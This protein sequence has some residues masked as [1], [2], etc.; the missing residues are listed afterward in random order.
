M[1]RI[2]Q[3]LFLLLFFALYKLTD[4]PFFFKIDPLVNFSVFLADKKIGLYLLLPLCVLILTYFLGRIFCFWFCPLGSL[5]EFV[6]DIFRNKRVLK[7][8]A[9]S[10]FKYVNYILLI[11]I[12]VCAFLKYQIVGLVDPF[13]IL[14][15]KG[16]RIILVSIFLLEIFQKRFWC[17]Y[18]C[19]LGGLLDLTKKCRQLKWGL[20][21]AKRV[22][23][24]H[25]N[26]P[27]FSRRHFL[28]AIAAGV[29]LPLIGKVLSGHAGIV[30]KK[31]L[32]P[33]G[34]L[35]EPDFISK[36]I[37]CGAC[38]KVCVGNALHPCLFEAGLEGMAAPQLI[39][40]IGYCVF[41]CNLCGRVCPT[42]AI[43]KLSLDKKQKFV[44]GTASVNK[45]K[46]LTY[47]GTECLMCEGICP[48]S[49]KAIKIIKDTIDHPLV[50]KNLCIGCGA[51]EHVCPV[52][53]E[54][55]IRVKKL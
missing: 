48:V 52:E 27:H 13:S 28:A 41:N 36:C 22:D 47:K 34:A 17:M 21:Q 1:R 11:I 12:C 23:S 37:S 24:P 15:N 39:P 45:N 25:F 55:A 14:S 7:G 50:D 38:M 16:L 49:P 35:N 40:R 20:S 2:S 3:I 26:I 30:Q 29:S 31:V 46:C 53:G 4:F 6:S 43:K 33:P 9:R 10:I 32:R 44:I 51:C 5:L 42:S 18:L 54:A 19:P 8:K